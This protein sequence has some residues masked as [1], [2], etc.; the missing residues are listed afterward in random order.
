MVIAM[1]IRR[2][3]AVTGLA[4]LMVVA[5]GVVASPS[6]AAPGQP[7]GVR[8]P[9]QPGRVRYEGSAGLVPRQG[10]WWFTQWQVRQRVWPLSEGAGVVV[11][12]LDSGVQAS[13]PD[14]RGVVLS[15]TDVTGRRDNGETDFNTVGPGNGTMMS[16]LIAGQ[17]HGTGMAGIAPEAKILPVVVNAGA[18]DAGVSSA[19]MAAGIVYAVNHG[20]QVISIPQAGRTPSAAGCPAAE[21]A[22]VAYAVSRDV[23]VV[24][25]AGNISLTGTGPAQP[26]SCAGVLAVS[27]AGQDGARWPGGVRQ[28]YIAVAA[29]GA[30][31]ITSGRDGRFVAAVDGT[32]SASALAAAAA[33][34][35]R[36][37]YPLLPWYQVMRRLT[38]TALPEGGKVPNESS[39]YGIV[40]L[41]RA[42]NATAYPVPA[43][44][45]D[46][47]Y[48]KYQSWLATPQGRSVARQL[49][50]SAFPSTKISRPAAAAP[51]GNGGSSPP[52][53]L[54]ILMVLV[55]IGGGPA[56][57]VARHRRRQRGLNVIENTLLGSAGAAFQ[58][59]A[60]PPGQPPRGGNPPYQ[61]PLPSVN[62]ADEST[63]FRSPPYVKQAYRNTPLSFED[64]PHDPDPDPGWYF[65]PGSSP[66]DADRQN[67]P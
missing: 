16:V 7:G 19:A 53:F 58:D 27:A 31:L 37:R 61:D 51:G 59:P 55:I 13:V 54:A 17:G 15:G 57:A 50:G 23:V 64:A 6:W 60:G 4:G 66:P 5:C 20:A 41:D 49:A 10:E 42:V 44:G 21:Q 38:G 56:L 45:P 29:P 11:A 35:I 32:R 2:M 33:A 3:L 47:V 1:R 28:P 18:L 26:A 67:W 14:L 34:V 65:P 30:G 52:A 62:S 8:A 9:G 36:S 43:S 12:V 22:A 39:G 46:P 48:A 24:A 40:R 63:P 25:A